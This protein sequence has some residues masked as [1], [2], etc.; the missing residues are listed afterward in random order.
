VKSG[1]HNI[2]SGTTCGFGASGDQ[3]NTDAK[4]SPL[5]NNGGLTATDALLAGSPAIDAAGNC[6]PPT[7]D[8]RG[9]TRPQGA[10]CDIGAFELAAPLVPGAPPP[11]PGCIDRRKF[12]F[13]VHH[14]RTTKVVDVKVF[15][16]GRLRK[17][18][19]GRNLKFV[20]IGKLPQST[21]TV[22]IEALQNRGGKLV[23]R[24]TYRGCTK[25]R[26]KTRRAHRNKHRHR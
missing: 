2:D 25:S 3:S 26:P 15:I 5:Q 13:H 22:R 1:G 24:R 7:T 19:T 10:A 14:V 21:F 8:Q 9:V 12:K 17:H 20:T 4:L 16:N 23:S 18:V 11:P 6:P